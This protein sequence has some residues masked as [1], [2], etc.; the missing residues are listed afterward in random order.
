MQHALEN[1]SGLRR[2]QRARRRLEGADDAD[3]AEDGQSKKKESTRIQ[4]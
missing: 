2:R 4:A 3:N 1:Y